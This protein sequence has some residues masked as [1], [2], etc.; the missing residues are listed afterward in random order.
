VPPNCSRIMVGGIAAIAS[1]AFATWAF[2]PN[3]YSTSDVENCDKTLGPA[4]PGLD[5]SGVFEGSIVEN[6]QSGTAAQA[7]F[8]RNGHSVQGSY[9]L[10][11]ICGNI[12]GEVTRDRLEFSWRRAGNSGR[13]IASQI[14]DRVSGTFGL[15]EDAKGGGTFVLIQRRAGSPPAAL[16]QSSTIWD[17]A[18]VA[19]LNQ[20]ATQLYNQGRYSEAI[21]LAQRALAIQEKALGPDHPDVALSLNNLAELYRAQNADAEPLYKR[22]LAIDETALGPN[23][24]SVTGTLNNLGALYQA[25][26]RYAEAEPLLKRSLAIK[27][28]AF[29]PDHP[30]VA[31]S[32]N[33][34]GELYRIQGHYADAEPLLKRSLAINEKAFGPEH[35][36]VAFSLNNLASLY[37][38]QGRYSEA[39]PR[40]L[41]SLAIW[42]K[43]LGSD[44][45]NV[46]ISLNN[47]GLLYQ[48]QGRIAEAEQFYVDH[49]RYEKRHW[50]PITPMLPRHLIIWLRFIAPKVVTRML[51]HCTSGRC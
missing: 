17:T 2:I 46:A 27:E 51:S 1:L 30:N 7:K 4:A 41:R 50:V 35:P 11:E 42:E 3:A 10:G 15:G 33:N 34:L 48:A 24:A 26:G 18:D 43:S 9:L 39:E 47:L 16:G 45:P 44:H 12:S 49:W 8:V 38:A 20:Q 25:Q 6:G 37:V 21:P 13:G 5:F 31:L 28:R 29:G 23:H 22:S 36:N 32:L 19:A 40:Y 14:A